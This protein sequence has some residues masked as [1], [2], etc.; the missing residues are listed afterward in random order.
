MLCPKCNSKTE[1][2]ATRS[3][4]ARRRR[5]CL[6]CN[7]QFYTQEVVVEPRTHGGRR[8]GAGVRKTAAKQMDLF[9]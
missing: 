3:K 4:D 7:F 2:E 9:A 5:G 1:V 8:A 6:T